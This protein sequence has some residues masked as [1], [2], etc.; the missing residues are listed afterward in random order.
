M[1]VE[2]NHGESDN[3]HSLNP[4]LMTTSSQLFVFH[5]HFCVYLMFW[6]CPCMY[7]Y[8]AHACSILR[9]QQRALVSVAL[10]LQMV[11]FHH[12][13]TGNQTQGLWKSSH[14]H[15]CRA[16]SLH[17]FSYIYILWKNIIICS[18]SKMG[19]GILQG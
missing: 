8:A 6:S 13:V 17:P 11:V 2:R 10:E 7:F 16:I 5:F 12:V 4:L 1:E 19:L 14:T 18:D 9:D 3:Q 15:S